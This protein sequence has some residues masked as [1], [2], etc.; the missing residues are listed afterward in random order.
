MKAPATVDPATVA[1]QIG[2]AAPPAEA[3]V[4]TAA[5]GADTGVGAQAP[6]P[7]RRLR[8]PW[9]AFAIV[10]IV[11]GAAAALHAWWRQGAATPLHHETALVERGTLV[12]KVS[13]TGRLQPTTQVDVGSEISGTIEAVLVGDNDRVRKGQVLARLDTSRLNDQ[14]L[15]SEGA[16]KAAQ[17]AL[18]LSRATTREA[19]GNLERAQEAWRLSE[20][21]L[22]SRAELA[23]TEAAL[24]KAQAG[25]LSAEAALAQAEAT[26]RSD[27]TNLAKAAIRSPI[28]GVVLLRKVE[29]G[30]TVAA[31]LQAPVLFTLAQDLAQMEL[32]VNV[33][34]ADVGQVH[35]G[36]G[37]TFS[38]DA[39]PDR[40]YPATIKRVRY[41][42][43]TTNGVVTY[44]A[45]L[46][47]ANADLSLRPGMTGSASITTLERPDA[48]LVPNAA[49]RY[50]P[51]AGSGASSGRGVTG[52][53]L[54]RLA[55]G[56]KTAGAQ[57]TT[58]SEQTVWVPDAAATAGARAVRV[59]VGVSDGRRTEI[60]AG[61]LKP[62][63]A[64]ITDSLPAAR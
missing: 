6:F 36:Q 38:V 14:A 34:E 30:Q 37:A 18:Q 58:G 57:I 52:L 8:L 32:Q 62:G 44:Q 4:T 35:E 49:L 17:A 11:L 33:D 46:G 10:V 48:L 63:E 54:P 31:S 16:V 2:A 5:D 23:A 12:V 50:T 1:A 55:G 60:A 39:Y 56:R 20:G 59:K 61:A 9:R 51:P 13:A 25:E 21:R 43:E 42:S 41:G 27:R 15:R 45:V 28:D 64:V 47:V 24:E 26:L 29:P 3:P 7:G 40:R 53:L 22:P 19:R